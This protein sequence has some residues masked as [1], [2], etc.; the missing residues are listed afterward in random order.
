[1]SSIKKYTYCGEFTVLGDV[2]VTAA[3]VTAIW[4]PDSQMIWA[5]ELKYWNDQD[6]QTST[7]CHEY[8]HASILA[9]QTRQDK[10]DT[11]TGVIGVRQYNIL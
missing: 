5:F 4:R 8:R 9:L 1:M 10:T 3:H 2:V 11:V 7:K 6:Q